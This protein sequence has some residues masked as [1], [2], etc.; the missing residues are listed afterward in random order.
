M[1]VLFFG[2]Q[3]QLVRDK[4]E[5]ASFFVSICI[6]LSQLVIFK[7][8]PDA[9]FWECFFWIMGGAFGVVSSIRVHNVWMRYFPSRKHA[10]LQPKVTKENTATLQPDN[11][12]KQSFKPNRPAYITAQTRDNNYRSY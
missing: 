12:G 9:S 8:V 1:G 10:H 7:H 2:L 11:S 3:S 5:V 6:G 4:H